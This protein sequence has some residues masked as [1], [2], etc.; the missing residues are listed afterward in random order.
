MLKPLY[1]FYALFNLSI[2]ITFSN[3]SNSPAKT[4]APTQK[5]KE[6]VVTNVYEKQGNIF[7]VFED[8]SEKQLSKGNIDSDPFYITKQNAIVCVRKKEELPGGYSTHKIMLL[9]VRTGTE[10]VIADTKPFKDEIT[11]S[12]EILNVETPKMSEDENF[13]FFIVE[14]YTNSSELVKIDLNTGKWNELFLAENYE[15]LNFD[16]YKGMFLAGQ[17]DDL[18]RGRDIYYRV[19]VEDGR[20]VK[21]LNTYEEAKAFLQN[22]GVQTR[23][24]TNF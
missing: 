17:S 13:L 23:L 22:F 12:T 9:N 11:N 21:D 19:V 20:V 10:K 14:K 4:E 5:V 16:P 1:I 15:L 7:V 8:G 2:L 24:D 3:C 18:D 6:K